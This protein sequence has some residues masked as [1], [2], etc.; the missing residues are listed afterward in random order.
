VADPVLVEVRDLLAEIKELLIPISDAHLGGYRERQAERT[1]EQ[2]AQVAALLSSDKRRRAWKLADG[3]R[4]QRQISTESG[5][6]EGG[7][8]KFFKQLRALRVVED[9]PN[10]TR[11]LE[12]D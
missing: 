7:T 2:R 8:S 9:S 3:T 10:P 12:V 4:T 11:T 1:A 5:M 6:D